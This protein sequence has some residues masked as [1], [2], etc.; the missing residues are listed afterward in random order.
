MFKCPFCGRSD[1]KSSNSYQQHQVRNQHCRDAREASLSNNYKQEI[2][3]RQAWLKKVIE[4]N[5]KRIALAQQ[6]DLVDKETALKYTNHDMNFDTSTF[7][8]KLA[9]LFDAEE[10]MAGE[11]VES[12]TDDSTQHEQEADQ[13]VQEPNDFDLVDADTSEEVDEDEQDA[14]EQEPSTKAMDDFVDFCREH[15]Q[16]A[17]FTEAEKCGIRL[18]DVLRNKKAP[19]NA[20]DGLMK[21]HLVEQGIMANKQGVGEA[22]PDH[23][24]G[25]QSLLKRLAR[26][27]NLEGKG[28]RELTVRLPSSKEVVK[29]PVFDAEQKIV[30]L[31]SDPRLEPE[32]FDYF[33]DDPTKPPPLNPQYIGNMITSS[34]FR[35]MHEQLIDGEGQRLEGTPFYI[36][37]AVTGQFSDL[38]VT[39]VKFSL[40][41][42]T[43]EARLKPYTWATLGY[44][45]EVRVAESRGKK[46]FKSSEHLEAEDIE[47]FDGEG[48]ELDMDANELEDG[49]T[50]VKAQDFHYM[51]SV[52]LESM[53]K[54]QERGMMWHLMH[55]GKSFG[56][57]NYKFYVNIVRCDAEEGDLNC[58]K[59]L[60]RTR[61]VKQLCRQ[62]EVPTLQTN[63]HLA[64][65]RAKT[66]KRIQKLVESGK[67]DELRDMS[68]HFLKNAWY[69]VRFNQA[70]DRGIHGACPSEML[71]AMQLGIFKYTRDIFFQ[72]IGETS[73]AA[74]DINGLARIYG[75]LLSRQSERDLPTTNF[76]KGIKDGKLMAKD[77]RGVLLVMAAVIRSTR[78][79]EMLSAKGSFKSDNQKDDWLMLVETL[80]QWEAY[81]C[82][83]Q[84]KLKD[85]KRLD[86]KHRYIMYLM[87]K[88]ARRTKG[89]GL[90]IIKFHAIVHL[91]EDILMHGV[92]LEFDTAA[93]ESH[94]KIA[95]VAAKLTQRNESTFNFQVALRM[96]E[97][98]ILDLAI[99]ELTTGRRNSDYFDIFSDESASEM[100]TDGSHS[101][102]Q[103]GETEQSVEVSTG[104][105]RI[106]VF[107]DEEADQ[108]GFELKSRSKFN[109]Q[110]AMHN[111]LLVFLHNLQELLSEHLPSDG[112]GI[113]TKHQRGKAIFRG[114]P[115]FRGQG[116]WKDWVLVDWAGFGQLPCHISC[117]VVVDCLP[118][119]RQSLEFG[120]VTLKNATYAV[121]EST[122]EGGDPDDHVVSDLFES[123]LKEVQMD[124]NGDIVGRRFYLAETEAIVGSCAMIPDI[125]GPPNRCLRVSNRGQWHKDFQAWVRSPHD[126]DDMNEEKDEEIE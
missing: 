13:A 83:P 87:K 1:F 14:E 114:H 3:Q 70:N 86:K 4:D 90:N 6:E 54:L 32:D 94:H 76:S 92:P 72:A 34:S 39:A 46:L 60:T 119:G 63:D 67:E 42:F 17:P 95:K 109:D 81:L 56:V 16:F 96:W 19:I 55:R 50:D 37:G 89:M 57:L 100:S 112:L 20:Y 111:D 116:P 40:T 104:D 101:D 25:R 80:L 47:I 2:D 12:S 121:V 77:Y 5:A 88:V 68:Q 106:S 110:T 59:Y 124:V 102:Q 84:M 9:G 52:I 21:W 99:H 53:V 49:L 117:F 48:E 125:G 71:H 35:D 93:N 91:M 23:F 123:H 22:G 62:C 30:E 97:F 103:D 118:T 120:G 45:P 44:L 43:R 36:D 15:T 126:M 107:W 10:E 8:H 69:R 82:L 65:F 28:P 58:G 7:E 41:C 122:I 29:I 38:P 66:Q 115:N 98:Y 105:A 73:Q 27:Y 18:M 11:E 78:G 61:N 33:D 24:I 26:R 51:L 113:F 85:V 64:N 31:L 74:H 79:R 75:K 108:V